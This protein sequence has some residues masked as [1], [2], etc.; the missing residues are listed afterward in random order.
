M[1]K[2]G[3]GGHKAFKASTDP[4]YKDGC[5]WNCGKE[6]CRPKACDK[7]QDKARQSRCYEAW[8]KAGKPGYKSKPGAASGG[9]K[10]A[11]A[12]QS[13]N[14]ERQRKVWGA[15]GIHMVNGALMANCK[16]CGGLVPSHTTKTHDEWAKDPNNYKLPNNHAL[17]IEK[18][19]LSGGNT[20]GGQPPP[21]APPLVAPPPVIN[22]NTLS[23]AKIAN[24]ER[25]STGP[26][27]GSI[28]EAMRAMMLN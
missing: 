19:K 16:S 25:T 20:G 9:G 2:K 11:V 12:N 28:A 10:P 5:C 24:Y 21:V 8:K 26:N 4:E 13:S 1:A 17:V 14:T 22:A 18:T 15:C 7:P 27:A 6:G 3:G 23:E